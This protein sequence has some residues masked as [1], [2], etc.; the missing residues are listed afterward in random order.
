MG[1]LLGIMSK[2]FR[3]STIKKLSLAFFVISKI[4]ELVYAVSDKFCLLVFCPWSASLSG[5]ALETLGF[6]KG[7]LYVYMYPR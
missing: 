5:S 3:N 7:C 2:I 1:I 6:N 4:S